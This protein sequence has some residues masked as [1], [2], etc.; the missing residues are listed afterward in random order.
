MVKTF[1]KL[2]ILIVVFLSYLP[3]SQVEGM[4]IVMATDYEYVIP[5]A[6]TMHSVVKNCQGSVSFV[7]FVTN[8]VL[9]SPVKTILENFREP[10]KTDV[11]LVNADTIEQHQI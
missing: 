9:E 2:I 11:Y 5:T 4:N 7:I 10:G 6:I 1:K 3:L 8:D